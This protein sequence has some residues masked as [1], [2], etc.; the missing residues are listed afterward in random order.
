MNKDKI[1]ILDDLKADYD[2]RQAAMMERERKI[3]SIEGLQEIRDAYH[4]ADRYRAAFERMM[5]DEA[6]DGVFPP[7]RPTADIPALLEKYPRA[8]A[9]LEAERYSMAAHYVKAAAGRKAIDAIIDGEDY[10]AAIAAMEKKWADHVAASI[11]D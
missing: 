9:Y 11:W 1:N 4:A 8:A 7:T 6:N 2:R 5:D 10:Q 3:D